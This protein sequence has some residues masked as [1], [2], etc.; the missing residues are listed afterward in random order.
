MAS[1]FKF[2]F[3]PFDLAGIEVKLKGK[4]KQDLLDKIADYV[5]ESILSDVGEGRSPVTGRSFK[6]LSPAY[7]KEKKGEG[8][9]PVANLELHGDMLDA[10]VVKTTRNKLSVYVEGASQQGK[11]DGHNNFTGDSKIPTRKFIPAP[12]E[13]FR[14]DIR[15]GIRKLIEE[16]IDNG[17]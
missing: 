6:A 1:I 4:E 12:D 5:H 2:N 17:D 16:A 3:D 14:P 10:L 13:T 15:D 11:V 7:A 9:K 8:S